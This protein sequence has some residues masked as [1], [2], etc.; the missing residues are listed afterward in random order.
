MNAPPVTVALTVTRVFV[1]MTVLLVECVVGRTRT[2]SAQFAAQRAVEASARPAPAGTSVTSSSAS[3]IGA[4]N[5]RAIGMDGR[6]SVRSGDVCGTPV[7][8]QIG[9]CPVPAQRQSNLIAVTNASN[10]SVSPPRRYPTPLITT[11]E[12]SDTPTGRCPT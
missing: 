6:L 10:R 5:R 2:L 8:A 3:A 4:A 9:Y 1:G 12:A 7:M 11:A